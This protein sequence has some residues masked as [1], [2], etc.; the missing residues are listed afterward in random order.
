M[1]VEGLEMRESNLTLNFELLELTVIR[2]GVRGFDVWRGPSLGSSVVG[3]CP[4]PQ[5]RAVAFNSI[6]YFCA[7]FR[8]FVEVLPHSTVGF[9]FCTSGSYRLL[10]S[11]PYHRHHPDITAHLH[12]D[13]HKYCH[14]QIA[15]ASVYSLNLSRSRKTSFYNWSKCRSVSFDLCRWN[16]YRR[17]RRRHLKIIRSGNQQM[18]TLRIL[19]TYHPTCLPRSF[20]RRLQMRIVLLLHQTSQSKVRYLDIKEPREPSQRQAQGTLLENRS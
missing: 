1:W 2:D 12:P 5:K 18:V 7:G 16:Q 9:C 8:F 14:S 13:C 4:F 15:R 6:F 20:D 10:S 19:R 3:L 17:H 11:S